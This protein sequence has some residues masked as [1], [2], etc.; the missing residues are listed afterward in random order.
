MPDTLFGNAQSFDCFTPFYSI[1]KS[2]LLRKFNYKLSPLIYNRPLSLQYYLV[3]AFSA[4]S[5]TAIILSKFGMKI[6]YKIK[7]VNLS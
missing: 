4:R 5:T 1:T 6:S 3:S 7:K 2:H